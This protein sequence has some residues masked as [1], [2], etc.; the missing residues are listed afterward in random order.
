MIFTG[1]CNESQFY[2][3]K[4]KKSSSSEEG[5]SS[6]NTTSAVRLDD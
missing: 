1:K 2:W 5:S 4:P 6:V 3:S